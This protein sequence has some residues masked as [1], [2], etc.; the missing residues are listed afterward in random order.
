MGF[1]DAM[2]GANNGWGTV[3]ADFG[4]GYIGP[5]NLVNNTAHEVMVSSTS[6][7]ESI[8][9]TKNDVASR[10][11]LCATSDWVKYAIT[12]KNGRKFIATFMATEVTKKGKSMN[13]GLANFEWWMAG[14]IYA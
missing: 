5:K 7:K 8:V 1:L 3:T 4:I 12:L 2:K 14:V 9:F 6:L 11:L 13:M 10:K